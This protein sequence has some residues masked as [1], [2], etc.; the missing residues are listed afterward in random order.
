[1]TNQFC[2]VLSARVVYAGPETKDEFDLIDLPEKIHKWQPDEVTTLVTGDGQQWEH[3]CHSKTLGD[4]DQRTVTVVFQWF[5]RRV[6]QS[7]T[8]I[9]G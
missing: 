3:Q 5:E 6:V 7:P 1:M 4:F 2:S 9:A 8:E